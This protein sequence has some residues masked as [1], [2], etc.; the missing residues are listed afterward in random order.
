VRRSSYC[1]PADSYGYGVAK[2]PL[3]ILLI[4][5]KVYFEEIFKGSEFVTV[6]VPPRKLFKKFYCLC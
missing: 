5:Q 2:H 1:T 6:H 3:R 4:L